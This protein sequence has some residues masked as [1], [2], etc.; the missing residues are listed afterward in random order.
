[1][2]TVGLDSTVL[3]VA[4]P[5][6]ARDLHAST[7]DLQWFSSAY[8]LALAAVLLPA[9]A[10][11]DRYGRKGLLL[12]ALLAFGGA[13]AWCAYSGGSGDLIAARTVLGLAAAVMMPLSVAVLPTLFPV[14]AER[15]RAFTIWVTSTAIGLPLGQIIGG[16]LLEHFWWGSIF[17][18][19][20]PLVVIGVAAVA[21]LVP[22][23]RS[24]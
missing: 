20:V 21:A 1:M 4:L 2:L 23:S 8:T 3:T 18:I 5:T 17:L 6:L 24:S 12:G 7:S 10:L 22:E 9:G 16:W 11:G 14:E 15:A 19:N 13:S